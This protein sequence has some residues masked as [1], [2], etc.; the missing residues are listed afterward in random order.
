MIG[1]WVGED[2]LFVLL[3]VHERLEDADA[4]CSASPERAAFDPDPT[5]RIGE[6]QTRLLEE[7]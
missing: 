7:R 3:V 6:I 4:A 2:G 5:R 1:P